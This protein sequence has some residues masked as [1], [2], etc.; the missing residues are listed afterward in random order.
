MR[1]WRLEALP[2]CKHLYPKPDDPESGNLVGGGSSEPGPPGASL[3]VKRPETGT[4]PTCSANLMRVLR[5]VKR[6]LRAS[7]GQLRTAQ[8]NTTTAQG[9][10]LMGSG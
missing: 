6:Q 10:L 2:N 1:K 5:Q 4:L 8:E 9:C 7:S 3:L